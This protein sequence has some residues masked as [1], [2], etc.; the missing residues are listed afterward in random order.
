MPYAQVFEVV[1]LMLENEMLHD[2]SF[3]LP[4]SFAVINS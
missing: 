3:I 4:V 2:V 1:Y